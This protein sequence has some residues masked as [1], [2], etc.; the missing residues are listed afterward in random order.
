MSRDYFGTI[1][2][3]DD[4]LSMDQWKYLETPKYYGSHKMNVDIIIH[5]ARQ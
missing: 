4:G 1:V 2:I 5:Y 3:M